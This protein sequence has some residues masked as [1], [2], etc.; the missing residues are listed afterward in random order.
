[1]RRLFLIP[2]FFLLLGLNACHEPE[3]QN[4]DTLHSY[5]QGFF[6]T[7]E[8]L[9]THANASLS[10]V[11]KNGTLTKEIFKKANKQP[12]G[13]IA[14]DMCLYDGKVF[15][16]VNASHK[17]VVADAHTLQHIQNIESED[18]KNPRY[19]RIYNEKAYV[20]NWGV[21][22]DAS[23]D[24][25]LVLDVNTYKLIKRIPVGFVPNFMRIAGHKLYVALQG[26]SPDINNQITVIDMETD[27][28]LNT[29]T[30]GDYPGFM[31]LIHTKLY[32]MCSGK[33]KSTSANIAVIDT[34]TDNLEKMWTL[35][36]EVLPYLAKK[37]RVLYY[38]SGN[39]IY[40]WDTGDENLP[41]NS[42]I[43]I[44]DDHIYGMKVVENYLYIN[45]YKDYTGLS[46]LYVY[47]TANNRLAYKIDDTGLFSNSV[48]FN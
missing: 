19:I 41:D 7:S 1:M 5:E 46:N 4:E 34:Q 12:L 38:A 24:A 18:I 37:D 40:C 8:G 27:Q 33:A 11:D 28:V 17:I 16:V 43:H 36:G 35:S 48:V 45:T 10:Y 6:I 30:V 21:G 39:D 32:V 26:W 13:D 14:Q 3:I 2:V 42:V 15:I 47:D 23:D 9:F 31:E 20:S 44:D 22:Q 25:V 29:I